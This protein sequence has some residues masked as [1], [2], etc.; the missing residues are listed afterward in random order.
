MMNRLPTVYHGLD[1]SDENKRLVDDAL[2]DI[3]AR[4]NEL[5]PHLTARVLCSVVLTA[6]LNQPDPVGS[7]RLIGQNVA[8]AINAALAQPEGR[9]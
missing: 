6:C 1:P 4:L 9:A 7:F 3:I 8:P 2:Q 5:P